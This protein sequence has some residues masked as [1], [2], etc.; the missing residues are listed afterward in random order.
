MKYATLYDRH[1]DSVRDALIRRACAR[2]TITYSELAQR[3]GLPL[4]PYILSRHLPGLLNDISMA[5]HEEGWPLLGVLVLRKAD[6]L[7]GVGF[8]QTRAH[9]RPSAAGRGQGRRAGL[10]QERVAAGALGLGGL[11]EAKRWT[12]M[13]FSSFVAN[14]TNRVRDA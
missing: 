4:Q 14:I 9:D 6:G 5:E 8:F 13:S 7:P 11:R 1:H 2:R 3:A 10:L 12:T